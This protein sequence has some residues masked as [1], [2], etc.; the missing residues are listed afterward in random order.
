M[1]ERLCALLWGFAP[2]GSLCFPLLP[3]GSLCSLAPFGFSDGYLPLC[4]R[5][6]LRLLDFQDPRGSAHFVTAARNSGGSKS[7]PGVPWDLGARTWLRQNAGF[8][9]VGY[10][11]SLNLADCYGAGSPEIGSALQFSSSQSCT[12]EEDT[13]NSRVCAC[14]FRLSQGRSAT[15]T[16]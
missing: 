1:H 14:D 4:L 8:V 10:G 2:C 11:F 5:Q 13:T 12:L 7:S 9:R 15:A 3:L 6:E 16:F